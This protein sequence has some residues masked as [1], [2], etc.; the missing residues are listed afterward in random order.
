VATDLLEFRLSERRPGFIRVVV[1]VEI[2]WVLERAYGFRDAEIAAVLEGLLQA[3]ASVI[4]NEQEVFTAS[5][6]LK[7]GAGA[8]AEALRIKAA[9]S[10]TLT[11]DKTAARLPGFNLA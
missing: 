8:F 2:V 7:E 6:A 10:H 3:D 11:F 5:M 4:Q 9:C 1:M